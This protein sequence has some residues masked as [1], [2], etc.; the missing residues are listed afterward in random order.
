MF[1]NVLSQVTVL[2]ILIMLGVLL[3][4]LKMLNDVTVKQ[5]T[6]IV[7]LLVTPCVIIK[8]FMREFDPSLIKQLL[9]SF[10]IS[11]IVHVFCIVIACL[12]LHER[13]KSRE[14]VLRFAA[15]FS[16]CGFMSV[17]LL[18]SILGDI[19]VFYGSA[20][21]AVFNVLVWSYGIILMS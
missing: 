17:P 14:K 16:N 5:M 18:E 2:L 10:L 13:D 1:F 11:V 15:I 8:S 3:T 4:K 20:Y 9:L 12:S 19:G 21:L 7:L 6:D